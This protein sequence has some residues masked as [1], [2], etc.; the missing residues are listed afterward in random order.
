MRLG[1][2][3]LVSPEPA[4]IATDPLSDFSPESEQLPGLMQSCRSRSPIL[5]KVL[6]GPCVALPKRRDVKD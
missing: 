2:A 5:P 4:A 3:V 6:D 1:R